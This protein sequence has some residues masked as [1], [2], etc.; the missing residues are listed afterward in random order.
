MVEH[1]VRARARLKGNNVRRTQCIKTEGEGVADV[2]KNAKAILNDPRQLEMFANLNR[3]AVDAA[4]EILGR[5][6]KEPEID[7]TA[8]EFVSSPERSD[9]FKAFMA[10]QAKGYV[11]GHEAGFAKGVAAGGAVI[12][13]LTL[14]AW[15]FVKSGGL[16]AIKPK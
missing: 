7:Q 1:L 15:A 5:L 12:G 8:Q 13:T 16:N 14:A 2:S 9:D 6:I 11:D 3:V 4:K 10:G